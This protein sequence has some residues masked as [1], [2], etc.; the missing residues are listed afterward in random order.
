MAELPR[1][2]PVVPTVIALLTSAAFGIFV[3]PAPEPECAPV[4]LV[5][6]A[7]DPVIVDPVNTVTP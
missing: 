1:E 7:V 3:K 2:M 5:N 4:I 6:K